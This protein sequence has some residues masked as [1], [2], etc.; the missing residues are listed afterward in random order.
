MKTKLL[1][2]GI[3]GDLS[4]RKLLPAIERIVANAEIELEVIGVSRRDVMASEL[5]SESKQL[6]GLLSLFTMDVAKAEEYARLKDYLKIGDNDQLLVYL[7]VPP[8][9]ATQIVDFLGE[10]EINSPNVKLLFEKPFGVDLASAQEVIARTSRFYDESQIYR[11]DHYLA[12]EMAQN[13]VSLRGGN[14]L[15]G[16]VW[17]N[18]AIEKIE[19]QALETLTIEGRAQFYE[20]TGALRDVVQGHLMQLLSLVLMDIPGEFDWN[21]VPEARLKA[22]T[23]LESAMPQKAWRGQY[24]GYREEVENAGSTVETFVSVELASRDE[25]WTGVPI[26][27]TTG[28]AMNAKTTEI[29]IHF[30]KTHDAQSNRLVFHVQPNEGVE[31]ELYTKKP[32]YDREFEVKKLSFSYAEDA[33]LPDAYEQVL[34]DAMRSHKSLFTSSSEVLE[35]WRVL[36]PLL[37]AWEMDKETPRLYPV[38]ASIGSLKVNE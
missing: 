23:D 8:R 34:I 25:R 9:A 13:I 10:A 29:D 38:G 2:F 14:A 33:V 11:I 28:K 3:T 30:R 18:R 1:I 15:F 7:S 20:Q 32:G 19:V 12:K 37:Y 4:T 35:S 22:L 17:N 31:I 21:K 36:Q 24:A 6:T 5:F 26:V 16:Y 27:L